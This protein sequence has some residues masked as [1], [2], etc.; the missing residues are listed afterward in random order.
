[1]PEGDPGRPLVRA[2]VGTQHPVTRGTHEPDGVVGKLDSSSCETESFRSDM[3][4]GG[5][6]SL[7]RSS[8]EMP[9]F[10]TQLLTP[11]ERASARRRCT[12]SGCCLVPGRCGPASL[13]AS[14]G[15]G[16]P[17]RPCTAGGATCSI[18]PRSRTSSRGKPRKQAV[19]AGSGP[20]R[21]LLQTESREATVAACPGISGRTYH[22]YKR[23]VNRFSIAPS[24]SVRSKAVRV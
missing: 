17:P 18:L 13:A 16:S 15:A 6:N 20:S 10:A 11:P 5:E 19:A 9:G 7:G 4:L 12:S 23:T 3:R 22:G 24:R 1:M 14:G 8:S 21:H 2:V